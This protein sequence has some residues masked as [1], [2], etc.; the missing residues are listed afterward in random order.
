MFSNM[1][2]SMQILMRSVSPKKLLKLSIII[3]HVPLIS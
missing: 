2:L 1:Q 3:V